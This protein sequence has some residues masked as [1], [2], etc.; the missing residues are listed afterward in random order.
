MTCCLTGLRSAQWHQQAENV[1][2]R[3]SIQH[4]RLH[5]RHGVCLPTNIQS[6]HSSQCTA[7]YRRY[8]TYT[9]RIRTHLHSAYSINQSAYREYTTYRAYTAYSILR[10]P[11]RKQC[12]HSIERTA[13]TKHLAYIT[14]TTYTC[15]SISIT[16]HTEDK[17]YKINKR[18][19][20][21][22]TVD[23]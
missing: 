6:R 17:T 2:V 14:Y 7:A 20:R 8:T 13:Y 12:T 10:T 9:S 3:D 16:K 23:I 18:E 4:T 1:S 22:Y 15:Q 21:A 19:L 5:S 11:Y